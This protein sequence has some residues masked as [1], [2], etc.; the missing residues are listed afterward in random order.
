MVRYY[1]WPSARTSGASTDPQATVL[2]EGIRFVTATLYI[3][4][5]HGDRT[6]SG[7]THPHMAPPGAHLGT[8][9]FLEGAHA[10][11]F[12]HGFGPFSG[13]IFYRPRHKDVTKLSGGLWTP[14]G[15]IILERGRALAGFGA[16][17]MVR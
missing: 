11:Q 1:V 8:G 5:T 10:L 12:F 6:Q 17:A 13:H 7:D 14:G 4:R 16:L 9:G 2:K 15:S 3:F